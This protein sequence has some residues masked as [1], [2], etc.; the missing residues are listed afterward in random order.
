MLAKLYSFWVSPSGRLFG[1]FFFFLSLAPFAYPQASSGDLTQMNIEDLMN[2][3]VTSVSRHEQSLSKTAA[4]IFVITEEEIQR[5]GATNIPDLLRMVPGVQVAQISAS[6][7]AVSIR[8]FNGRFSNKVLVMVDGRPVYVTSF[9][10]VFYEVLDVPLEQIS[11]IEVIRG[12]GG[13]IWGTN[14]VNGVINI[15]TKKAAATPG[16]TVVAG[17]GTTSRAGALLQQGG[18][19]RGL[20]DF[21]VFAKYLTEGSLPGTD[22]SLAEDGWHILH[23]GFRTDSQISSKDSLSVQGDLYSG[24]EGISTPFQLSSLQTSSVDTLAQVY[25]SGG[26]FQTS[27]NHRYSGRSDTTLLVSYQRY[28]R[29]DVLQETRGT[30]DADFQHNFSVGERHQFVWGFDYRHS[31]SQTQPSFAVSVVPPDHHT[32]IYSGFAQDQIVLLRDHLA[33]TIGAK[34]EHHYY[35]GFSVMPSA[36]IAW[37]PR[38]KSTVWAAVSR[39]LRAPSDMDTGMR[40][41]DAVFPGPGGLPVEVLNVGDPIRN[42]SLLAYEAGYRTLLHKNLSVDLAAYY[43][44]YGSL[45]TWEPSAPYFENTP[46]PP[47]LVMPLFAKNMMHAES[48][49]F[50]AFANWQVLPRWTLSPGY[51]FERIHLHLDPG[52]HDSMSTATAA[53]G[54]PVNSAQLRSHVALSRQFSWDTSAYF[55]DHLVNTSVASYT[56]LDTGLTWQWKEHLTLT[57]FGQNLLQEHHLE[58][59]DFTRS[60]NSSLMPRGAYGKLTWHF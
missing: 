35:T 57:L 33:L 48:H 27:W 23:G 26:F 43:N 6:T 3:E 49:G 52:S 60:L 2:V 22:G 36:R 16:T 39:A 8:G 10:G 47:H 25:L 13:A 28:A 41:V 37:T 34:F 9:D 44:Q 58:F 21:R 46:A 18:K 29:T 7:W 20:G 45:E 54:T 31:D 5:S 4:A 56:R 12:P 1:P 40:D 24:R 17:G 11:R 38:S 14:A 53:E 42:E 59:Q 30:L 50:E 32:N 15:L 51:A 55:V 19:A